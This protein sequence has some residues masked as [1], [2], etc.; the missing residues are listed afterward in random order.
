MR[1]VFYDI[2]FSIIF[3]WPK[4]H[5]WLMFI[6]KFVGLSVFHHKFTESN[7]III[8]QVVLRHIKL[9]MTQI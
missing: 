4:L 9:T 6:Y 7:A 1:T 2:V 8:T 5:Y 3:L